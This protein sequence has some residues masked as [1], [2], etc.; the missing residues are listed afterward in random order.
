MDWINY[1]KLVRIAKRVFF[2]NRI[3]EIALTNKRLWNFMNWVKK[4]KLQATEAIKFNRLPCNNLNNLW[5][6]LH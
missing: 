2:N 5:Q 1:R 3:Q 4:L 6:A